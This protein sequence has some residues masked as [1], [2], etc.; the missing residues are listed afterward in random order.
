MSYELTILDEAGQQIQV[1]CIGSGHLTDDQRARLTRM[2]ER[3]YKM[4]L[5]E[6]AAEVAEP[7]EYLDYDEW[8]NAPPDE[9]CGNCGADDPND[10]GF[11]SECEDEML[12]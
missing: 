6:I 12:L 9:Y 4:A 7:Q 5:E 3:A 11:C 8:V 2:I 1:H 10:S